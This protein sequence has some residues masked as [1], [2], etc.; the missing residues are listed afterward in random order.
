MNERLQTIRI[1]Y[2]TGRY[3]PT[4]ERTEDVIPED[5]VRLESI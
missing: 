3:A 5:A 4:N 2:K 1:I